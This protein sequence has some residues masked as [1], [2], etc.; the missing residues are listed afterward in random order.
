M[1]SYVPRF[2]VARALGIPSAVLTLVFASVVACGADR[3]DEAGVTT[4]TSAIVHGTVDVSHRAVV[5]V[6][7]AAGPGQM[8]LCS[9][10]IVKVDRAT[11]LAWV[12]TAAHCV[13]HPPD[14]VLLT[15]DIASPT[16]I[17]LNVVDWT[18]DPAYTGPN[19]YEH[20]FAVVRAA[21]ADDDTPVIPLVTE[22]SDG[23]AAGS[24]VTSVG[25]GR[26]SL[27]PPYDNTRRNSVDKL[28]DSVSDTQVAY[29]MSTSG[30]CNGDS[31][32]PVLAASGGTE[33]VV[34]VHSFVEGMVEDGGGV[35]CDGLG[36]SGRVI[37]AG[38]FFA[39]Q[40][41]KPPP[42]PSCAFCQAQALSG[43]AACASMS[44]EC[45]A[46]HDCGGF[47]GCLLEQRSL[48][49]CR[50]DFPLGEGPFRA[51]AGCACTRACADACSGD[52]SC[53]A[54]PRCGFAYPSPSCADCVE[55]A[56]CAE[57]SACAGD[58]A[59]FAC[60]AGGDADPECGT[61]PLRQSLASCVASCRDA[62]AEGTA[63]T[64]KETTKP[65]PSTSPPRAI[66]SAGPPAVLDVPPLGTIRSCAV[67]APGARAGSRLSL[68][69]SV[70]FA[71]GA[72]ALGALVRRRRRS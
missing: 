29:D 6:L 14:V 11:K 2:A 71:F 53:A 58:G 27:D 5:A 65:K 61:L 68:S 22:A 23:L 37:A 67:V 9:G 24:A 15:D 30:I 56:C 28:L 50:K 48:D 42:S 43:T 51:A 39:A 49:D 25:F 38:A 46:D 31:G 18:A 55:H 36:V 12:V 44:S 70:S 16:T 4:T 54:L 59:C 34:A 64:T 66:A 7:G 62:C 57:S 19:A 32:G 40:L 17:R 26:T 41:A 8:T 35:R 3:S 47:N 21:G 69:L 20:D 52:A 45:L 33:R 63:T 60:V 1:R 13:Q 72:L 10:T